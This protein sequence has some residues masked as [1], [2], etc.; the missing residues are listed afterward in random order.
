LFNLSYLCQYLVSITSE[1]TSNLI[2]TH[3]LV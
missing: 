3:T 1:Y 2:H